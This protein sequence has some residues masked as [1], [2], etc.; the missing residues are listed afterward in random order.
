MSGIYEITAVRPSLLQSAARLGD[1]VTRTEAAAELAA[2]LGA[3]SLLIFIRDPEIGVLLSAPGF[4]QQFPEGKNWLAFLEACV[5]RGQ[6]RDTLPFRALDDRCPVIGYAEGRDIVLV[7]VGTKQPTSDVDW[8]RSLLPLLAAVF[9]GEQTATVATAQASLA[10]QSAA[11]AAALA[12]TLGHTRG[13]LEE[14]LAAARKAQSELQQLYRQL[15]EQSAELELTNDRL[16]HQAE[17]LETQAMEMEAQAE[18]LSATNTA[19]EE[20]RSLAESANRAKSEFLA[21]MSHELRTPLNAIGGHVQLL[22]MG[23]HGPVTS[24]QMEALNRVERNQ[25][26]LLG[27]INEVLNL[28]RIEAGRVDYDITDVALSEVLADLAPM[29]EPQLEAK[30][31]GYE[32]KDATH[33]P[34]VRGDREKL[35]QILLNLLSNSVKFTGAGGR[36]I[37]DAMVSDDGKGRVFIRVADTGQG[38]P[39][40]KLQFIFDPFTQVD[41]THSRVGQGT[42]LGLAISRDLARGM[43]GDLRARS[44]LGVGSVFTLELPGAQS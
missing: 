25:R 27:L 3:E 9:R 5:E 1:A 21:T 6:H 32:V 14:A 20:A 40:D 19:L 26:H 34:A 42:G 12:T 39:D 36:I 37:V 11:R 31:L 43:G 2:E 13:D 17:Q 7:L 38:I 30:S 35:Q 28:S 15:Q 18:E 24:D 10:R 29:I 22:A 23:I 33:L 4:P 8:L 16:T 41:G 44:E